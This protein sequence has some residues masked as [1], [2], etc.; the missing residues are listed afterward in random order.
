MATNLSPKRKIDDLV[1]E[2]VNKEQKKES[3]VVRLDS[4]DGEQETLKVKHVRY[5]PTCCSDLV[6]SYKDGIYHTHFYVHKFILVKESIYFK[7]LIESK[8]LK[9][10]EPLEL[11]AI[12]SINGCVASVF[13]YNNWIWL[14]YNSIE[15][16]RDMYEYD[17]KNA[18]IE[19]SKF[20]YYLMI[21][22]SHYFNSPRVE[23][24]LEEIMIYYS[25]VWLDENRLHENLN[26][27]VTY[28]WP[29]A[30]DKLL[31]TI[32]KNLRMFRKAKKL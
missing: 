24:K 18:E 15:V 19:K 5:E 7:K 11:P 20:N 22:M 28:H 4:L 32:A 1:E 31:D 27:S 6:L 13:T 23:K 26:I 9:Q 12:T 17:C 2:P 8:S 25:D 3:A 10:N 14:L 21:V 29:K 30:T 16:T